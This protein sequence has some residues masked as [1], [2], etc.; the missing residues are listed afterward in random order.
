MNAASAAA[1]RW[2]EVWGRRAAP[3]DVRDELDRLIHLDG[4]D[5]GAGRIAPD[6]WRALCAALAARL[7]IA[8]DDTL[9]E[10][11]CGAG[12]LLYP[13][14]VAGHRVA[15]CDFA[16]AQVAY[17]AAAMPGMAFHAEDAI[18]FPSEPTYDHVLANGVFHY[19]PTLDYA[20]RA[21]GRML[22]T[23]RKTVAILDVPDRATERA[24][25]QARAGALG[26]AEYAKKYAGLP[27]RYYQR[28]W[29]HA[30]AARLGHRAETFGQTIPGYGNGPFRF[31]CVIRKGP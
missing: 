17:A 13:F 14:Y 5:G 27:H 3:E 31:N 23:A 8:P 18:S 15:G 10:V 25:E 29:F 19:F 1:S 21:I 12:A 22:A 16:A 7:G 28:A 4:F 24:S 11:G 2:Q 6:D 20:E 30:V 26:P 9:F